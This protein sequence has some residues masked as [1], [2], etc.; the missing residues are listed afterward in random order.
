MSA[1]LPKLFSIIWIR[2]QLLNLKTDRENG[3][4]QQTG[5]PSKGVFFSAELSYSLEENPSNILKNIF[6]KLD[7]ICI[8]VYIPKI[9]GHQNSM[10]G[11][12]VTVIIMTKNPEYER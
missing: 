2:G 7:K 3:T 12:K 8:F 11:F 10:I 6:S 1:G 4:S 9:K 5:F